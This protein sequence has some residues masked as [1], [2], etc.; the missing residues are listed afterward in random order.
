MYRMSDQGPLLASMT[1]YKTDANADW[2]PIVP[3]AFTAG[4]L[5]IGGTASGNVPLVEAKNGEVSL[6]QHGMLHLLFYAEPEKT[7]SAAGYA[8]KA[9]HIIRG[10]AVSNSALKSC[11]VL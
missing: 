8:E 3:V 1:E 9:S 4:G 11:A 5:A 10:L 6:I 7:N 2:L